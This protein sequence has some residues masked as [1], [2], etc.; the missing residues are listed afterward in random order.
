MT[1][2]RST[3]KRSASKSR[4]DT[5]VE[6]IP[7]IVTRN[8]IERSFKVKTKFELTDV[9][10]SFAELCY[11]NNTKMAFVDGPA[12]T[13]KTYCAA[14]VAL[15]MLKSHRVDE[16][17]YIRSIIESASKS[18]GSLPGEV[19]DKFLPWTLPLQEKLNELIP[20]SAIK[21][22]FESNAIKAI[23]VNYVRGLTF[24][25]SVVIVDEAQNLTRSELVTILTRFGEDS[26]MIVIGD[27]KQSDI[28][29]RSGF[30]D[31][32]KTFDDVDSEENG[33]FTFKFT[34]EDI[35]RSEMLKFIVRKLGE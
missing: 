27:T 7:E 5:E 10:K 18:M 28:N 33:V 12:G 16:I 3:Y 14:Y 23:P 20:T 26:K 34:D 17:V 13:A 2:R 1:K 9:H 15:N 29:G 11:S 31:I 21:D 25:D 32:Y 4:K 22:L 35:V 6:D 24:K 19:D 8:T 30:R